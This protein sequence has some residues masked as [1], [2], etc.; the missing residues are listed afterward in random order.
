MNN[1]KSWIHPTLFCWLYLWSGSKLTIKSYHVIIKLSIYIL[2]G[3]VMEKVYIKGDE[4]RLAYAKKLLDDFVANGGDLGKLTAKSELY[5]KINGLRV[6]HST[7]DRLMTFGEKLAYCGYSKQPKV[8]VYADDVEKYLAREK[9]KLIQVIKP[10]VLSGGNVNKIKATDEIYNKV[11]HIKTRHTDGKP[12]TIAEK[13]ALAGYPLTRG[14]RERS[15]SA[16]ELLRE[17]ID[18]YINSGGKLNTTIPNYPFV[19]SVRHCVKVK[20]KETNNPDLTAEDYLL[21]LG[22]DFH[23]NAEIYYKRYYKMLSMLEKHKDK[24]GFVDSYLSERTIYT[25]VGNFAE[26]F[27]MPR[28]V[29]VGLVANQ[30]KKAYTL[31]TDYFKEAQ[32]LLKQYKEKYGSYEGISTN[33]KNL[34]N[35]LFYIIN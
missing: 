30:N 17:S 28:D 13:F 4:E 1:K 29:V 11:A 19:Q 3:E 9:E 25:L 14:Q 12:Y 35:K 32:Y 16:E 24:A 23:F 26:K 22:Y 34:S 33:D 7:E 20:R 15:S 6:K 2:F 5:K 10:F 8:N 31:L 18:K 27:D 21:G